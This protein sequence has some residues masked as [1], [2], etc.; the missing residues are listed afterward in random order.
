MTANAM[1]ED[2]EICINA[3]M[4]DYLGK[5]IKLSEIISVLE[6]WYKEAPANLYS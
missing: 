2:R 3:G 5:P 4:D 6:K 1:P